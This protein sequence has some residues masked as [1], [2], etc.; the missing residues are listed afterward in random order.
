MALAYTHIEYDMETGRLL[1][2]VA[3]EYNGEWSLCKKDKAVADQR[4]RDNEAYALNQKISQAQLTKS[5]ALIDAVTANFKKELE[6]QGVSPEEIA[7]RVSQF[8]NTLSANYGSAYSGVKQQIAQRGGYQPGGFG[9]T[10]IGRL[11]GFEANQART[12]AAGD[13]GIRIWAGEE[14]ARRKL[15]AGTL[16][17]ALSGTQAQTATGFGNIAAS[18]LGNASQL[19]T[20]EN[21]PSPLWGV[22]S[23]VIGAGASVG[24]SYLGR[25]KKS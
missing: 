10:D 4:K 2:A 6:G 24:S 1:C 8:R 25:D 13:L 3:E 18:N 15:Q 20:Q 19:A 9:G 7:L 21:R 5:N 22:L 17:G 16:Y 12:A 23:S 11:A 14:N